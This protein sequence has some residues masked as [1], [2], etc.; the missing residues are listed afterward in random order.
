MG[1]DDIEMAPGHRHVHRFADDPPGV[2]QDRRHV[3]ELDEVLQ[4]LESRVAPLVG[5]ITHEGRAEGGSK[6]RVVAAHHHVA[7]GVA[8]H[9][10]IAFRHLGQEVLDQ[11]PRNPYPLTC[12]VGTRLGPLAAGVI[13]AEIDAGFLEDLHGGV[14]KQVDSRLV[15]E[16]VDRYLA[17]DVALLDDGRTDALA[18]ASGPPPSP[19]TRSSHV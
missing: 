1:I 15:E 3:G 6:H 10:D 2:V 12:H 19:S 16:L 17:R 18:M 11:G 13:V 14:V 5:K 7:L 4:V 9:L 8:R